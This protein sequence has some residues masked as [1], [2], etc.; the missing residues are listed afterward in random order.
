MLKLSDAHKFMTLMYDA[1]LC[2]QSCGPLS[3]RAVQLVAFEVLSTIRA[4]HERGIQHGDVK[5]SSASIM[6]LCHKQLVLLW[7]GRTRFLSL[8]SAYAEDDWHSVT[9]FGLVSQ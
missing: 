7:A 6:R 3:E 2:V 9:R 5:V 4:C 8:S 1:P